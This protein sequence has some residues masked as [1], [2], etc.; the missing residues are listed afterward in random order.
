MAIPKI[1][2]TNFIM[3]ALALRSVLLMKFPTG[4]GAIGSREGCARVS[5][6]QSLLGTTAEA[7]AAALTS[8]AK[9]ET[10]GRSEGS[11]LFAQATD[12]L[13]KSAFDPTAIM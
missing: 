5:L 7:H 10:I 13:V 11:N 6:D 1:V 4:F 12:H 9:R 2:R 8:T 3:P